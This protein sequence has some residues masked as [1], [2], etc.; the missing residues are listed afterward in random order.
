MWFP[1]WFV[2]SH[3]HIVDILIPLAALIIALVLRR[4]CPKACLL[5]AIGSLLHLFVC[6][7]LWVVWVTWIHFLGD[8][9]VLGPIWGFY[10][11]PIARGLASILYVIA[12]FVDRPRPI[13]MP[14][15][16]AGQEPAQRGSVPKSMP[17]STD[18]QKHGFD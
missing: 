2:Y 17:D 16:L 18:I 6:T 11:W 15:D 5:I 9:N 10:I 4:R 12:A 1:E 13:A 7:I 3:K 14:L 8:G